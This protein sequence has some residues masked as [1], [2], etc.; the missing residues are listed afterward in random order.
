MDAAYGVNRRC[1]PGYSRIGATRGIRIANGLKRT[2]IGLRRS[3]PRKSQQNSW[4]QP[5]A[6]VRPAFAVWLGKYP[7]CLAAFSSDCLSR[8]N[9]CPHPGSR[10]RLRASPP[11]R[12][13]RREAEGGGHR[14]YS[15]EHQRATCW[16]NAYNGMT[17]QHDGSSVTQVSVRTIGASDSISPT[18]SG[19]AAS[20]CDL[21]RRLKL[22]R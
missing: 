2:A 4:T 10:Q 21:C 5:C 6:S 9:V 14:G 17:S 19:P 16:M 20:R 22:I 3:S 15:G 12:P 8:T 11:R 13:A 7:R 1:E 18:P